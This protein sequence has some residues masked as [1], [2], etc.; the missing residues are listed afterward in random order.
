MYGRIINRLLEWFG[1]LFLL[2][3]SVSAQATVG[4]VIYSVDDLGGGSFQYN[5]AVDNRSATIGLSGLN[6]LYGNSFFGLDEF[7]TAS[8]PLGWS[9]FTPLPGLIDNLNY[10]STTP[11]TNILAGSFLSGFSFISSTDPSAIG[12][13][14]FAVEGITA[15]SAKQVSLGDATF[16]TSIPEPEEWMMILTGSCLVN[17]QLK[18]KKTG[19]GKI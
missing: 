3:A 18:R 1:A 6:I 12:S 16:V 10:F 14:D 7:S 17:I 11:A 2:A 15:D 19:L 5:I 9:N 13:G 8:Q 4:Q